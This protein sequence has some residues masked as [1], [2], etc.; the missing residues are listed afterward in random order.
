VSQSLASWLNDD[1]FVARLLTA[2]GLSNR[3]GA[4]LS[5]LTAAV[6]KVP[7]YDRRIDTFSSSEGI[8]VLRGQNTRLL[9]SLLDPVYPSLA[10]SPPSLTFQRPPS[11]N[12]GQLAVHV[13]LANTLFSNGSQNTL[14]ASQW[15]VNKNQPPTL[16]EKLSQTSQK[17]VL[18]VADLQY[19][20]MNPTTTMRTHL[21]PITPRAIA[22]RSLGNILSSL[23]IDGRPAPP[24][25]Q[26]ESVIPKLLK[27]PRKLRDDNHD[28]DDPVG[29]HAAV[30]ALVMPPSRAA[31]DLPVL[32][33]LPVDNYDPDVEWELAQKTAR[34][35]ET[36]LVAGCRLHK[37]LSGGGG[38]GAKQ[39]L[40]SLDPQTRIAT[41]DQQ[42]LDSFK[43]S[44]HE[45]PGGAASP[46]GFPNRGGIVTP[47]SYVQ[48]FV[49]AAYPTPEQSLANWAR[50]WDPVES[51]ETV[52]TAFGTPGAVIGAS[53]ADSISSFPSLFG[54]ISSSGVYLSRKGERG[55]AELAAK[56]DSPRSY[57]ISRC[58][59]SVVLRV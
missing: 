30:W 51:G 6:D 59:P 42:D 1:S 5:V 4:E 32:D 38:W 47:G 57:L 49:E 21:V 2:S 24:S 31:M 23:Q 53:P 48:F 12:L 55:L 54:A 50:D 13:P 14:F 15:V 58:D 8:S 19:K 9:P 3:E 56:M 29:H 18:P 41:D 36:Y 22:L 7:R 44:F 46:A 25:Q 16:T 34:A 17:V 20:G 28:G 35:M 33:P 11:D 37:V 39:G 52:T 40:L 10:K 27:A 45:G 43:A 26:L